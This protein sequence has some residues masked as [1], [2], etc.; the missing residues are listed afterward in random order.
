MTKVVTVPLVIYHSPCP[1]GICGAWIA[2]R[3]FNRNVELFPTSYA[4][5]AMPKIDGREVYIID[6]SYSK[7]IILDMALKA[8]K[9]VVLDHHKS[10]QAEL[11]E[12]I[13]KNGNLEIIFNM[14]KSGAMLAWEY[15]NPEIKPPVLVSFCEDRDLWRWQLP[16][17]REVNAAVA[18]YDL[19]VEVYD[20]LSL[21]APEEL[22][23]EGFA[24]LRYQNK[25]IEETLKSVTIGEFAGYQVPTV[26]CS[27]KSIASEVGNRMAK[28]V[29]FAVVWSWIGD[30]YYFSLRSIMSDKNPMGLDVSEIAKSVSNRALSAGG[31]KQAAGVTTKEF[32]IK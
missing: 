19:N 3:H 28:G 17:S 20:K 32:L 7:D 23:D 25:E 11:A 31:H 30:K 10:A 9:L 26:N 21:K 22:Y 24:I 12:L 27:V 14:D 5:K 16:C 13:G 29:P 4:D 8:K 15:F 18:S 6:F 1:D 2:W